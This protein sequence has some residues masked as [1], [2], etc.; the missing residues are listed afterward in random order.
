M[1]YLENLEYLAGRRKYLIAEFC[2]RL[3]F[4]YLL[5]KG[6]RQGAETQFTDVPG[7]RVRDPDTCPAFILI[8]QAVNPGAEHRQGST[9]PGKKPILVNNYSGARQCGPSTKN[10]T[11][12]MRGAEFN[13]TLT[14]VNGYR[15]LEGFIDL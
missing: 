1:Y 9:P 6:C 10:Y 11:G 14:T 15:Q 8:R 13:S 7:S 5:T 2:L 3:L 4:N 12:F